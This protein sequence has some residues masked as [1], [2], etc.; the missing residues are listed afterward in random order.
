MERSPAPHRGDI[1]GTEARV[2]ATALTLVEAPP[3]SGR[4]G[5]LLS[6]Q[7]LQQQAWRWATAN[8][9]ADGSLPSGKEIA[10]QFGRH[11]RW[12][13]LVKRAGVTG[14]FDTKIAVGE[15]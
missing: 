11:E 8:R 10:S 13:R 1:S 7:D 9:A 12:G 14:A 3:S 5:R 6:V 15:A 2:P 4:D